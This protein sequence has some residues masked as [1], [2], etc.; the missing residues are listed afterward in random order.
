MGLWAGTCK[1]PPALPARRI[2]SIS[3]AQSQPEA[4][5]AGLPA[6]LPP[7]TPPLFRVSLS[8]LLSE[9]LRSLN[10]LSQ[11][12]G[13]QRLHSGALPPLS[14][15]ASG[16]SIAMRRPIH[17]CTPLRA[18][19]SPLLALNPNP[20]TPLCASPAQDLDDFCRA[21]LGAQALD[22]TVSPWT[23]GGAC[24]AFISIIACYDRA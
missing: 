24:V 6:R 18:P 21:R 2:P 7:L 3:Q 19:R 16:E 13:C 5:S 12:A 9:C 23:W 15:P 10:K 4:A 11:G 22:G 14:P 1:L 8:G 20:L 17:P